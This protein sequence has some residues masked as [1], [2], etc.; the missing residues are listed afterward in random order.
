MIRQDDARV[1][2]IDA[3]ARVSETLA[4]LRDEVSRLLL[5]RVPSES[6]AIRLPAPPPPPLPSGPLTPASLCAAVAATQPEGT[7]LVDESL[8]SGG[9]YWDVSAGCPRF[10]HLALTGGAIGFGPPASVGAAVAAPGRRVVNLQ[11]DG[12]GL[13]APQALWTQAR[14]R[15]D[16]VTVVCAN[17][18]Y[19]IL[20]LELAMQRVGRPGDASR[21]LTDVADPAIRWV[22][23]A[24]GFG[25][26]ARSVDT[27][28]AFAEAMREAL[29]RSGPSLIEAKL[30]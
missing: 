25:V 18:K 24:E 4:M 1:W 10:T 19:A 11:A 26:P 14:E 9:S 5:R 12:S 2:D 3:G 20:K 8:T 6:P 23:L 13:Y 29:S 15:L 21:R 22:E 7:I 16:V 30:A 17:A 27:A 28:E